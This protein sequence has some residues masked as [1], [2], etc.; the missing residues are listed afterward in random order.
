MLT[1]LA[2]SG[3]RS[4]R[5]VVV[6]LGR[7]TVVTGANGTGKS[8]LYRALRLLADA[9]RGEAVA[10]LA[11]E[12]GL[13]STL[14]AGPETISGSMRRGEV[15]VQGTRRTGPVRLQI[16]FASDSL[17]Y[18]MDLGLPQ[19][20]V[21]TRFE[22]DP[23]I[24]AEHVWSGP[25]PR[26]ASMLAQR[27]G[28]VVTTRTDAGWEG[29]TH[30]LPSYSSMLSELA[31]PARAPELLTLREQMR[32]WRFYDH[33]RT[34]SHAPAR[35]TAVGTRTPVLAGDGSD[36]AAAIA[37]I[38][39]IGRGDTLAEAVDAAFDGSSLQVEAENGRF[40]LLL[41]Q[42]GMLRPLRAD[43]LSDGTLRFLLLAAALLSPRPPQLFVLN[44]PET[45]LHPDLLGPLA[46]MVRAA[47]EHTQIVLVTHSAPLASALGDDVTRIELVK[48][49]GET[50]VAGQGMLSR[51]SWSWPKR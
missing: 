6:E 3:Y 27:H 17:G 47:S 31:D 48:E 36:L 4:L 29:L 44:E 38:S 50:R 23:E 16:G 18:A 11:R 32:G 8:S 39:E 12:G 24:K 45:S 25:A 22:L 40:T 43:E 15:P 46:A 21:P 51:P 13:P 20:D 26:P 35:A 42:P 37:T 1:T 30:G 28:P 2:I 5:D 33:L 14:W 10:A 49:L 9:S 19:R 41:R 7:V 34:D